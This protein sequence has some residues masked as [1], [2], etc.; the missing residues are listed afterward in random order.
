MIFKDSTNNSL[1]KEGSIRTYSKYLGEQLV[2]KFI[3]YYA[4]VGSLNNGI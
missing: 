2:D 1:T 4:Y 3:L